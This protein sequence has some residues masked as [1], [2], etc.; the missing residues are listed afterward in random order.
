MNATEIL[1][2]AISNLEAADSSI[3]THRDNELIERLYDYLRSMLPTKQQE[4]IDELYEAF[5]DAEHDNFYDGMLYGF[6][7]ARCMNE[8]LKNP[9][10]VFNEMRSSWT[11]FYERHKN[12]I[13]ILKEANISVD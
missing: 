6:N 4:I 1:D 11:S 7:L 5:A 12:A 13:K 3:E 10:E 2:R 9:T 8:I